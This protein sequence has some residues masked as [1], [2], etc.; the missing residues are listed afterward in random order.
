[1]S[2]IKS[3][4]KVATPWCFTY[5]CNLFFFVTICLGSPLIPALALNQATAS[6]KENLELELSGIQIEIRQI[7]NWL[8]EANTKLSE[9]QLTL[10]STEKSLTKTSQAISSTESQIE[11]TGNQL[12]KLQSQKKTIETR[13]Q[14]LENNLEKIVRSSYLKRNTNFFETLFQSTKIISN[15]RFLHSAKIIAQTQQKIRDEHIELKNELNLLQASLE[16]EKLNI[17]AQRSSLQEQG[18]ELER[19]RL[20]KKQALNELLAS[21]SSQTTQLQTLESNQK[22]LEDLLEQIQAIIKKSNIQSSEVNLFNLQ[23]QLTAPVDGQIYSEFG[24]QNGNFDTT[25]MGISIKAELGTPVATVYD[26]QIVFADWL[27]GQGLLVIIDHGNEYLSLYGGN[28]ALAKQVGDIVLAGEVIATS[29]FLP[30]TLVPGLY[31]EI[32]HQGEA[33]NPNNWFKK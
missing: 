12:A 9:E 19:N 14:L 17:T 2:L 10:R 21:I 5:R 3:L 22:E 25:K 27:R 18:N 26:G 6:K 28:E 13:Q 8:I 32:R 11:N 15:K 24:D 4:N 31:F 20:E 23:G 30:G 16:K 29:G 33:K 1:M 7:E